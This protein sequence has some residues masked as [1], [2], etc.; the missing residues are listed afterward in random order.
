LQKP[1]GPPAGFPRR[2]ALYARSCKHKVS[3]G[4][5]NALANKN[6]ELNKL[7]HETCGQNFYYRLKGSYN[8]YAS[9]QGLSLPL[10]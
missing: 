2:V 7:K 6:A 3:G 8:R 10:T 1:K 5:G 9:L 4:A